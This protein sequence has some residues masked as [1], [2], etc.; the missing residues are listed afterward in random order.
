MIR[1][2]GD[3]RQYYNKTICAD[4]SS[5]VWFGGTDPELMEHLRKNMPLIERYPESDA[6]DL[7]RKTGEFHHVEPDQVLAFNLF[8]VNSPPLA[9]KINNFVHGT[10]QIYSS[11]A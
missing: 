5:N 8:W 11:V 2:H 1:G 3:D 4:F 6:A 7:C 10:K 9:A